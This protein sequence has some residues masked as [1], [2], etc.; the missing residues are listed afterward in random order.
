MQHI[1]DPLKGSSN[2]QRSIVPLNRETGPAIL[3]QHPKEVVY[4]RCGGLD[5]KDTWDIMVDLTSLAF[6]CMEM[7]Q[8]VLEHAVPI[9]AARVSKFEWQSFGVGLGEEEMPYSW[10]T[11]IREPM[12]VPNH[13][14]RVRNWPR[15]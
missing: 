15:S 14:Y 13:K 3:A 4:M 11:V 7:N 10:K 8:L 1:K 6:T 9:V 2:L 5:Y 12:A